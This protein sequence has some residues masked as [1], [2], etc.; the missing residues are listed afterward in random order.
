MGNVIAVIIQ[1]LLTKF[2]LELPTDK[3][4]LLTIFSNEVIKWLINERIH[5][6]PFP[7]GDFSGCGR[8]RKRNYQ[9]RMISK[10]N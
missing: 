10:L 8:R 3:K 4:R 1:C 2:T 7:F 6:F 9:P 5:R